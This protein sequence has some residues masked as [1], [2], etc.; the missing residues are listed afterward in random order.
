VGLEGWLVKLQSYACLSSDYVVA[1]ARDQLSLLILRETYYHAASSR[2][3]SLD[4]S[5][6]VAGRK[7]CELMVSNHPGGCRIGGGSRVRLNSERKGGRLSSTVTPAEPSSRISARWLR[8]VV[9]FR[10]FS[11]NYAIIAARASSAPRGVRG[12]KFR[13][14]SGGF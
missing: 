10:Q 9:D 2:L 8:Q 13:E 14:V 5:R 4:I 11:A 3:T 12:E 6:S 1:L 7:L